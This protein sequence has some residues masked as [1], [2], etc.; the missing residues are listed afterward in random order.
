MEGIFVV[1][2]TGALVLL[3]AQLLEFVVES[4][5]RR[6]THPRFSGF[7]SDMPPT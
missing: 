1:F 6:R 7:S 5:R 4:M 2:G 3:A